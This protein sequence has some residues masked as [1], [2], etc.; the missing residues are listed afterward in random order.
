H[1]EFLSLKGTPWSDQVRL[2]QKP[3]MK[4]RPH[5]RPPP[6]KRVRAWG[7][8]RPLTDSVAIRHTRAME[9]A[10]AAAGLTPP[11]R[12]SLLRGEI[13]AIVRWRKA[14]SGEDFRIHLR[15][16]EW[17]VVLPELVFGGKRCER[18]I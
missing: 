10:N 14:D 3:I 1:G 13:G 16:D 15:R 12:L 6:A 9:S 5:R 4:P 2:D 11:E 7:A 8:K 17:E 18:P